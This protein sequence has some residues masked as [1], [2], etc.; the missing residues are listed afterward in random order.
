M[1]PDKKLGEQSGFTE[2]MINQDFV[3]A[4]PTVTH[5]LLAR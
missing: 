3:E 2:E 1:G 5:Q 4:L